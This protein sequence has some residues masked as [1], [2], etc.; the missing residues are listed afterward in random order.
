MMTLLVLFNGIVLAKQVLP[1]LNLDHIVLIPKKDD[2]LGDINI[3]GPI[4][5]GSHISRLLSI[6]VGCLAE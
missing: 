2:E 3:W 5:I 6:Q 4:T 1:V